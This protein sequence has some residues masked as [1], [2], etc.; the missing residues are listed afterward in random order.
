M[1][2]PLLA[3]G[4]QEAMATLQRHL[5]DMSRSGLRTLVIAQRDVSAAEYE[6]SWRLKESDTSYQSFSASVSIT[7]GSSIIAVCFCGRRGVD[8]ASVPQEWQRSAKEAAGLVEGREAAVAGLVEGRE[9][10]LAGLAAGMER[11]LQLLGATAVEDR[12]QEGVPQAVAT[13]LRA[14]LKVP[15]ANGFISICSLHPVYVCR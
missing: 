11:G 12:L 9:A 8:D 15:A 6:V 5:A 13:L 4:Q 14:G 3:A 10:G 7:D 2:L 1:L